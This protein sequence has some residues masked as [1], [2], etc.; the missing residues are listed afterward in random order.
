M[1][2]IISSFIRITMA[3]SPLA[4][5]AVFIS[6]TPDYTPERRIKTVEVSCMV[7]M[8]ILLF[9]AITG[10]A[11]LSMLGITIDAFRIAGG[12]LL[13]VIGLEMLRA[14]EPDEQISSEEKNISL[15]TRDISIIPVASPMIAGPGCIS[16]AI[17]CA[18]E[19]SPI[20]GKLQVSVS[21]VGSIVLLYFLMQITCR[22]SKWLTPMILKLSY[23]LS[24][25][26]V[27]AMGVQFVV[28]G[29]MKCFH[30]HIA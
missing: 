1:D 30:A 6:M 3:M 22:G 26:V 18:N 15:K 10:E 19:G 13:F 7:A 12:I 21:I 23:R 27:S 11:L 4:T 5:V 29:I 25:L 24:G 8:G 9:F 28:I 20:I 2:H 14:R 16:T 17:M